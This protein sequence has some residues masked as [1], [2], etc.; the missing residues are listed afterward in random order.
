MV[1]KNDFCSR[2]FV[3]VCALPSEERAAVALNSPQR[4]VGGGSDEWRLSL[5]SSSVFTAKVL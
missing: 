4:A 5:L 3:L 2:S 1:P